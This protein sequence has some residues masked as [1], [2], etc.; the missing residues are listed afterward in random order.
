MMR[1]Q[2]GLPLTQAQTGVLLGQQLAGEASVF[3]AA[4]YTELYGPFDDGL[5]TQA[6]HATLREADTLQVRIVEM[7]GG[8][9]QQRIEPNLQALA[10][11][12]AEELSRKA[13]M[14][15]LSGQI[16]QAFDPAGGYLYTHKLYRRAADHHVWLHRAHHL[17]L[18]GY[19][20]QLIARRTA[21]HYE[22]LLAGN[23][24]APVAFATLDAV[25]NAD[26]AYQNSLDREDDRRYWL[27]ELSGL[28]PK[29]LSP[30]PKPGIGRGCRV[31]GALPDA[32]AVRLKRRALALDLSWPEL[33]IAGFA[34]YL[35]RY[36]YGRDTVL[37]LTTMLRSSGAVARTPCS[38]M[39]VMPLPIRQ[40]GELGLADTARGLRSDLA[41]HRSHQRYRFEHLEFDL[42]NAGYPRG[43][44]G[45]EINIMPFE[46]P[47]RFGPCLAHTHTLAAGP[48][49]DLAVVFMTR[50]DA[51]VLD[52]DGREENYDDST[53]RA[54]WYGII[55]F[56]AQALEPS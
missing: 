4:E 30:H 5:F 25:L 19:G 6:L 40:A 51:I 45:T 36:G 24:L 8:Y 44:L 41:R 31:G 13:F 34:G 7:G 27:A 46:P 22:A 21:A 3:Y 16:R 37:G 20:F 48:V 9:R 32:V 50:G 11:A 52:L 42:E 33:L 53:L 55:D 26:Q 12:S 2:P 18:D 23:P 17:L 47:S 1:A 29:S 39:N 54:H 10:V 35:A 56:L 28:K 14:A 15:E 38:A 49:E 43:L